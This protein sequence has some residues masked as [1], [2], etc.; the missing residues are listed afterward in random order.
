MRKRLIVFDLDGTLA[1]SKSSIT[2]AIATQL[3]RLVDIVQVA[4]ISGG[5][6]PQINNQVISKLPSNTSFSNLSILPTCGTRFYKFDGTW[7]LLYEED[8]SAAEKK[9]ILDA[10]GKVIDLP[11]F[12]A[13]KI[14]GDRVEDRG[15]QI[16]FSALGQNAPLAEKKSWDIDFDRRK[17]MALLLDP[18][19]QQFS[20]ALGG[21]TSIDVTPQGV[22]KAYGINKLKTILS[23][24][25]RDMI[26]VGDALFPGGNDF[27]ARGTGAIC[28]QVRDPEDTERVIEA[29]VG[30]LSP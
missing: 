14:W 10:F 7:K 18:M 16:T 27:P 20:L 17:K 3:S 9:T 24:E 6:W 19:L 26:Y 30:C 25:I 13:P 11:E 22:D 29:I 8:F 15:S 12:K 21:L 5:A 4:V 23:V 1:P 2:P 28:I